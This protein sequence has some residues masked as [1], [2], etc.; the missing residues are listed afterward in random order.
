MRPGRRDGARSGGYGYVQ[1]W[2]S[3]SRQQ[4]FL[5]LDEF[6]A[7][8]GA[9]LDRRTLLRVEV[10]VDLVA[11]AERVRQDYPGHVF[12]LLGAIDE[13]HRFFWIDWALCHPDGPSHL[14]GTDFGHVDD[15][16]L[17]TLV[18]RFHGHPPNTH[19]FVP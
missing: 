13:H 14:G 19:S 10:P 11:D 7:E 17:I 12:E 8:D 16:G 6:W 5:L 18:V 15:G 1:D 9:Y 2:N 3:P 4:R